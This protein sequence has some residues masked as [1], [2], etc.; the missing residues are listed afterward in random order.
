[1][2]SKTPDLEHTLSCVPN[3]EHKASCVSK[4]VD[5]SNTPRTLPI[6]DLAQG[7][8]VEKLLPVQPMNLNHLRNNGTI[9]HLLLTPQQALELITPQQAGAIRWP[10]SKFSYE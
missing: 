5:F 2:C 8:I 9:A 3:L 7:T 1:M 6:L 4:M 10:I